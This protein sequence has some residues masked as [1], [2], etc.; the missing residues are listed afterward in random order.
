VP[1]CAIHVAAKVSPPVGRIESGIAPDVFVELISDGNFPV[2]DV[3]VEN[4]HPLQLLFHE[5]SS[6]R[7]VSQ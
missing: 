2:E 1:H 6:L 3:A 5:L 7:E 4:A